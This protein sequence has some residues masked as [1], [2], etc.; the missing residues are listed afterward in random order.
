MGNM[1]PMRL[2]PVRLG[3]Q[4]I[5]AFTLNSSSNA[6]PNLDLKLL[7]L[8]LNLP[9]TN[10]AVFG[11]TN[12]DADAPDAFYPHPLAPPQ[13]RYRHKTS[14]LIW[15]CMIIAKLLM[16]VCMPTG[17]ITLYQVR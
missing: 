10:P 3:L 1:R 11:R 17:T 9:S 14:L 4:V 15:I 7:T 12:L 8:T 16:E 13:V 6:N 2:S 5:S